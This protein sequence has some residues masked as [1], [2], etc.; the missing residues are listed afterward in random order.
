[1]IDP[2]YLSIPER[3]GSY[4]DEAIDLAA[5]G[6]LTL[7]DEQRLAVDA[8]LS[9][10][11]GGYWAALEAAILE[12]RQNGK[13]SGVLLPVVL[14]DMFLLPP[15]RLVWTAHLFRTSRDAFV[16]FCSVIEYS[17]TLSRRV[18]KISN[19]HGEESIE[20]HNG[21]KLEFLARSQR[22]G[23]GLGGKSVVMDEALILPSSAMGALMPTLSARENP[24]IRY[25]SSAC[26]E[27]SDHLHTLKQR[28]RA[29]G[30]P[31]LVWVEW[32]ARGGW[33]DPPCE[34]GKKCPHLVGTGGCALDDESL[35]HQANHTLG[36][37][38]SLDYVRAER[39]GLPVR[40]FG[41]ERLGWHEEVLSGSAPIDD[42]SWVTLEDPESVP[43]DPVA[44]SIEVNNDRSDAA[45][46]I[47]ARR[48]DGMI[49]VEFIP[50]HASPY[51]DAPGLSWVVDSIVALQER[52][53]PCA[54]V[55]DD[56][57]EAA[58]LVPDLRDRGLYVTKEPVRGTGEIVVTTWAGDM[59]RACGA[60]Y[61]AVMDTHTLRHLNQPELNESVR[62]A[63]WR[64]LGDA[65]AW[66]R[67]EATTNPAP[68][69]SVTLALHGLL[70]HGPD[71]T[72]VLEGALMA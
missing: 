39:R 54:I 8:M 17:S 3:V 24:Q 11:P 14:F 45:I 37:R 5:E 29:G 34:Q 59:A 9:Y 68:L 33:A 28:G 36:R 6:G 7:D 55:V 15:D 12:A 47:A 53:R 51:P 2:A 10:G 64:P 4:G 72:V 63:V 46:G 23:R 57:S 49:H 50:K 42:R 21:A 40:E 25:G 44:L 35:W 38:I 26:T 30:D 67:K 48:D 66:S 58:S 69:I 70:T 19:S 22:G 1:M 56:K 61:D 62:G 65:K 60:L 16:D 32:S 27:T 41:R 31:S 71:E 13:T 52:Q 43:V 20:L 18:K